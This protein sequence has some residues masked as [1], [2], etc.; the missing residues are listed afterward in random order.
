MCLSTYGGDRIKNRDKRNFDVIQGDGELTRP[1]LKRLDEHISKL[2]WQSDGHRMWY[3]HKN[4]YSCWICEL[5]QI[6]RILRD[7]NMVEG[8]NDDDG[9]TDATEE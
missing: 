5:L 1:Y 4:P 2:E 9:D 6:V 3:T 7:L 8:L